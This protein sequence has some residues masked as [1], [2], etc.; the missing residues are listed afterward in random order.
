[1]ALDHHSQGEAGQGCKNLC[2][3]NQTFSPTPPREI[4]AGHT[5]KGQPTGV[6]HGKSK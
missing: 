1:M 3:F 4:T 6:L 5:R 2:I